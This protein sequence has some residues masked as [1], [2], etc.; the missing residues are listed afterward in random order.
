MR[1]SIDIHVT[2]QLGR[3]EAN[4][5]VEM[6]DLNLSKDT[7]EKSVVDKIKYAPVDIFL[8]CD[9]HGG[10]DVANF[11]SPLIVCAFKNKNI[12]YP[13]KSKL[14]YRIYH[15]IHLELMRHPK[16]IGLECGCTAL[17][18]IRY[19]DKYQNDCIQVINL[20][21]C[22]AV[23]S[24]SGLA[25][26]LTKD[27]KPFWSD[28]KRRIDEVNLMFKRKDRIHFEDEDWRIHGLSV[29]RSFGDLNAKP[30]ISHE[31]ECFNYLISDN[32]EF[33]VMA[34][35]GL[36]DVLENHEVVNFIRDHYHDNNIHLYNIPGKYPSHEVSKVK[37]I[38]RKLASY[39]LARGSTDNISIIIIF[40]RNE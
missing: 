18:M 28:E 13:I 14:V 10:V 2:S 33:V 16:K 32:D 31:P 40:F 5:D 27:H 38:A 20:G 25:I 8:I 12:Q 23:L 26:P 34:C 15:N 21:D 19:L 11:I 29:S 9:G 39:A 6:I 30:H 3:R 24:R 35:D 36:W 22:R 17:L 4:E 1:R 7:K 37:C